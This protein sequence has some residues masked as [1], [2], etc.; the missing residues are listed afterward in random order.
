MG[1]SNM[2]MRSFGLNYEISLL[3]TGG[4]LVGDIN[5]WSPT[6]RTPARADSRGVGEATAGPPLHGI[7]D[8]ADL[9]PAVSDAEE[10][11]LP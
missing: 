7:G 10:S 9:R 2:D 3:T 1:S 5:E 4:D 6:T 8:A 11:A